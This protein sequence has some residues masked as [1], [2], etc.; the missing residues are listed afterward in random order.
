V[1]GGYHLEYKNFNKPHEIDSPC[2]AFYLIRKSVIDKVGFLDEDYF[3]YAEDLDLSFRVKKAGYKIY[4][5]PKVKVIHHKGASSGM[6]KVKSQA[7]KQARAK[8]AKSFYDTM[9][10][11]Y[12]KHYDNKYPK[13]VKFLVFLGVDFLKNRRLAKLNLN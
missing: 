5:Y 2:G 11:F 12:Q 7:L 1:F 10:I 4:Y 6:H 3:M 9:K 8:A 13:F